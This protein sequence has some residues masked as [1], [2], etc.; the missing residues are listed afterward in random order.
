MVVLKKRDVMI[1]NIVNSCAAQYLCGN[2]DI[3]IFFKKV[4][5]N[6]N[7]KNKYYV[8]YRNNLMCLCGIKVQQKHKIKV[9]KILISYSLTH[10]GILLSVSAF[11]S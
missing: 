4:Q 3:Y 10:P 2:H 5:K 7:L 1:I 9:S 11:Y 8:M 6:S